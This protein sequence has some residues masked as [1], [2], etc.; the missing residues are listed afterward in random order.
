MSN[1]MALLSQYHCRR[2]FVSSVLNYSIPELICQLP[3]FPDFRLWD[4]FYFELISFFNSVPKWK[5]TNSKGLIT[6]ATK[7][8]SVTLSICGV[9][10]WN[11]PS[12][13]PIGS[14][15]FWLDPRFL[16][17]L[18]NPRLKDFTLKGLTSRVCLSSEIS[19][20]AQRNV[21]F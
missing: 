10:V 11:F 4:I 18:C 21:K 16:K 14:W 17:N 1:R 5:S 19:L 2:F 8:C 3:C 12:Y 6:R 20:S 9:S 15:N 13:N 7:F